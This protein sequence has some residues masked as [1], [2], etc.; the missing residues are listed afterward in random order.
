MRDTGFRNIFRQSLSIAC[1]VLLLP[2]GMPLMAQEPLPPAQTAPNAPLLSPDQLDNLVAPVALY[3]DDLLSQ[4]LVA[5]T[6]PL[7]VVEAAQWLQQNRNLQGPQLMDAARQQDWDAS[8]QALVAFPDALNLLN[9]DI[10]WTTDLGNAFL[11][12][13]AE[14]MNAVQRMRARANAAGKLN[15][16]AQQT[17]TTQTDGGQNVIV[18]QPANPQVV[19]VPTYDPAY[20]WGPPVYGY[21]PPLY[22]PE[23][24]FGFGFG[25]GIYIGAFFG[26][27]GW[28]NWGWSPNWF[29]GAIFQHRFFFD[30]CGFR[31]FDDGGFGGRGI[32]A[33]N[34]W[35]RMGIPYP[36]RG[37]ANRFGAASV[38]G[39]R[40]GGGRFGASRLGGQPYAS[41]SGGLPGGVN[42]GAFGN[43]QAGGWRHFG[44]SPSYRGSVGRGYSTPGNRANQA[45]GGNA[46]RQSPSYRGSFGRSY[47]TPGNRAN[48][49]YGGNVYRQSPSYRG[50]FGGGRST[51]SFRSS[52]SFG[53]GRSTPSFRSSPSFGGGGF[54]SSGG[55]FHGGGFRS[56]GGGFHGGGGSHGG[57][58]R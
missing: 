50:S 12:Q 45:Y 31:G 7:E 13:Q 15:S 33:H 10:R 53:G 55:G 35:H 54:R 56:S 2:A 26:G 5:A 6:Y 30:H 27:L 22:Y 40:F 11:A 48:Q 52:P 39:G 38:A 3:P 34:P 1:A 8:V 37:L 43:N 28:G 41:V 20:V 51:P 49:A 36:N 25:P 9:S 14:V 57:G 44:A 19:Y 24:G 42:R 29:G 16:N 21:Y 58:R 17:V 23:I 46:Y 18:I 47:S 32:W 4:V